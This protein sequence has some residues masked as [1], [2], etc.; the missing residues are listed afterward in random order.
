MR[1]ISHRRTFYKRKDN[2]R[3]KNK[4]NGVTNTKNKWRVQLMIKH[5]KKTELRTF[6]S[7]KLSKNQSKDMWK[8]KLHKKDY[9]TGKKPSYQ[10]IPKLGKTE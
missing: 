6:I 9:E 5:V 7:I 1:E 4:T 2:D 8:H 10:Y 3:L